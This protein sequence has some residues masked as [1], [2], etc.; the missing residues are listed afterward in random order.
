MNFKN[1]SDIQQIIKQ[2]KKDQIPVCLNCA[3]SKSKKCR[4]VNCYYKK[5][6][7]SYKGK[8]ELFYDIYT[9][10]VILKKLKG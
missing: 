1:T 8:F 3:D 2:L 10:F 7:K 4:Y 5:L 6:G 9:Q